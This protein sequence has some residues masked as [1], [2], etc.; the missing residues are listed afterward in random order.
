MM[1]T[2]GRSENPIRNMLDAVGIPWRVPRAEL[3]AR[4]GIRRHAAYDWD[5]I[6]IDTTPPIVDGLLWPL[7]AQ[8]LPQFPPHLPAT[9]FT[10]V[11]Y[12]SDD[13]LKNFQFSMQR[14]MPTLGPGETHPSAN[15]MELCWSFGAGRL[16]LTV[17]PPA[18][19]RWVFTNPAHDRDPRLKTACH[20]SIDTGFRPVV[21]PGEHAWLATFKAVAPI[22]T[23]RMS[24]AAARQSPAGQGELEYVRE[25]PAEAAP[26]FGSVG[27]SGDHLAL[28]F[29]RAQLYLIPLEDVV[30]FHAARMLPAK[31]PG[32][33]R[34]EVE[35]RTRCAGPETKRL[36]ITESKGTEDLNAL[37]AEL[38]RKTARPFKLGDYEY[39]A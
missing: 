14:F 39:D 15:S 21:S 8:V 9:Q 13:A 35:C 3:A 1:P 32:G 24:D 17:W 36:T 31:G 20:L 12:V 33:A 22:E 6:E 29:Y 26:L 25:P 18:M 7:S 37:A 5:V 4:Y 34:L 10:G 28:I 2:D 38:A 11:V 16:R 23:G 30:G 19:Q 27:L